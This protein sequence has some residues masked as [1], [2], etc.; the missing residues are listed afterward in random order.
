MSQQGENFR[1]IDRGQVRIAMLTTFSCVTDG[2]RER[3]HLQLA[4]AY[5]RACDDVRYARNSR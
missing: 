2:S 1:N 3:R 5:S 4:R